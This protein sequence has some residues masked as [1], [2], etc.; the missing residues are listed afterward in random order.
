MYNILG[1]MNGKW[2]V[3]ASHISK[4]QAYKI[5]QKLTSETGHIHMIAVDKGG[6]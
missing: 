1:N 4:E 5:A 3:A 2:F 6:N